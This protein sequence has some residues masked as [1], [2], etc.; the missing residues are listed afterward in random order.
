MF[1][2]PGIGAG[3]APQIGER[4]LDAALQHVQVRHG[5]AIGIQPEGDFAVVADRGN[6]DGVA[7]EIGTSGTNRRIGAPST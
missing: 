4:L 5:G 1:P 3:E 7:G 2:R 6:A